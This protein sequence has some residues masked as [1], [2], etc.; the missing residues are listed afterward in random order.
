VGEKQ[1]DEQQEKARHGFA[2]APLSRPA[3]DSG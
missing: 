3:G 2:A 1:D